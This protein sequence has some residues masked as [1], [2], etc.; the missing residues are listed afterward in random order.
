MRRVGWTE[1][2]HGRYMEE[3]GNVEHTGI[4][5]QDEVGARDYGH[6]VHGSTLVNPLG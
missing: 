3:V 2:A 6:L 1:H 4:E 5:A